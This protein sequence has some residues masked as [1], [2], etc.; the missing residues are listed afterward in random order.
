[1]SSPN[2]VYD[3]TTGVLRAGGSS[4][5]ISGNPRYTYDPARQLILKEDGTPLVS[6]LK[7]STVTKPEQAP[8]PKTPIN[9]LPQPVPQKTDGN[10]FGY[11]MFNPNISAGSSTPST[12]AIL[13]GLGATALGGL[14]GGASGASGVLGSLANLYGSYQQSQANQNINQGLAQGYGDLS[15]QLQSQ[16]QFKPFTVTGSTGGVQTGYDAQG[17]LQTQ[18][19]LGP[20]GQAIQQAGLGGA[21]QFLGQAGNIDPTLAA[22]RG[23]LGQFFGSQA[24]QLGQPTGIEGLTGQAIAGG[25]Q[26]IGQATQ[27]MDINALRGQFAG[28]VGGYLGQQPSYQL[29][30]LGGQA[31]GMGAQALAQSPYMGAGATNLGLNLAQQG[32]GMLTGVGVPSNIGTLAGT[33]L[34]MG[35]SALGRVSP[36]TAGVDVTGTRLTNLG[37]QLL[38]QQPSAGIMQLGQQALGMG[39]QGL[40]GVTAPSDIEALRDQYAG[41]AGQAAGGLLT[42]T[43]QREADIYNRIRAAQTPE[44]QRQRLALEERLAAQGRL[45]TSSAAYGGATPEQLALETAQAE[46]RNRASIAAMDQARAEQQQQL[47]TAQTL[48]GMTGQFAGISSDLQSA[49][50][51]RASQLAQLG[52]SAEQIQSQLQSEGLGRGLQATQAGL[53]AKE[54][55]SAL[56]TQSQNRAAQ[57]AQLGLSAEQIQSQLESEGLGRGLQTIQAGLQAQ[58]IGSGLQSQAQQRATQLA[59]L[60]L[61]AEQIQSQLQSEGLGRAAQAG[62]LVSDLATAASGLETQALQRGLS[63]AGLGMQGTE[64]GQSLTNQQL[65]NLLALQQAG[66]TSA[67]AQQQLQAGNVDIGRGLLAAGLAPESQLLNLI[68]PSINLASLQGTA[69]REGANLAAQLAIAQMQAQANAAQAEANRRAQLAGTAGGLLTG[70]QTGGGP[71]ILEQIFGGI[72]GGGGGGGG[73][74]ASLQELLNYQVPD[75]QYNPTDTGGLNFN[76]TYDPNA[77]YGLLG[78]GI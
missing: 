68:Q 37:N 6:N 35:T 76:L 12:G 13:G 24:Q 3:P 18:Y 7:I 75:Y 15:N 38:G 48:G 72:F 34:G 17:N 56:Q 62:G 2:Y 59:Q 61:S 64:L 58:E 65:Q 52:L 54:L 42:G 55:A 26:R 27:P 30:Q 39:T 51:Q 50:Q 1:M 11:G 43:A 36:A 41:L 74:T 69:Q 78:G 67:L 25:Q 5:D 73:S 22:Q 45:G 60:G 16:V 46:A 77:S 20:Q 70:Q 49:A 9:E 47:A 31:Y 71:S 33:A 63:L 32:A 8:I 28:Q 10:D 29:G 21:G 44:E 53:G 23:T 40:Q 4:I 19:N 66:Q 57:L 14:F